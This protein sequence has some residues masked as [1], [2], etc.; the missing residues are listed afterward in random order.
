MFMA[1]VQSEHERG[2]EVGWPLPRTINMMLGLWVFASAFLWA[3][4]TPEQTNTAVV[5][6]L[7]VLF[8]LA[9]TAAPRVRYLNSLLAIWLFISSW[10]IPVERIGT[11]WS[12]ALSAVAIFIVSLS[13]RGDSLGRGTEVG[14]GAGVSP[15]GGIG[16][17]GTLGPGAGLGRGVG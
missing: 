1:I 8:A 3:H 2:P 7:C 12:N 17:G 13:S 16:P 4:A 9:A 11:V 15:G 14:P 5:G 10:A 6:A